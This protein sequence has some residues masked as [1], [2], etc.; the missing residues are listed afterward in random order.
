M[1]G[2]HDCIQEFELSSLHSGELF[3]H[4]SQGANAGSDLHTS[5][6]PNSAIGIKG[7]RCVYACVCVHMDE[8]RNIKKKTCWEAP[9]IIKA[10][11]SYSVNQLSGNR[12]REKVMHSRENHKVE[13]VGPDQRGD[14]DHM[15][16]SME[17]A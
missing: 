4:P 3:K 12:D 7:S 16:G 2:L 15:V 11:D 10:K 5:E 17:G 13:Q 1:Q 8:I 14:H 9:A 6:H